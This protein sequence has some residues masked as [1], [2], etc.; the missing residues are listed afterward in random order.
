MSASRSDAVVFFGASG[1]LVYSG[2]W[3]CPAC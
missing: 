3:Q 2:G 1:D